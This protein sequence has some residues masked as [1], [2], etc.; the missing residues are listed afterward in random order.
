MAKTPPT[1]RRYR[2]DMSEM[3]DWMKKKKCPN[4]DKFMSGK[5]ILP[6]NLTGKEKLPDV[7]DNAF[8]AYN[9]A[10]LREG[11]QLF[12]EKMLEPDVTIGM[13]LSRSESDR[14][15]EAPR[16]DRQRVSGV[17][18]GAPPGR[19]PA[20]RRKDAGAGRDHRHD[21]FRRAHAGGTGLLFDRAAHQ[22]RFCGLDRL[23]GRQPLPRPAL[24]AELPRAHGQLQDGRY[25]V[26][27]QRHRS[28]LRRA[29]GL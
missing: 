26:A 25:G 7:I 23:H 29:A 11:C 19:L 24:R 21:P 6:K 22:G 17:Q 20:F 27:R 16:R 28:R 4:R 5:R 12:A 13:T 14:Q 2:E 1:T 18:R 10:R 3:P 15:G 9:G 8:L